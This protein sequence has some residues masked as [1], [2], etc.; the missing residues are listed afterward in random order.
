MVPHRPQ[1]LG[2]P[3]PALLSL[4]QRRPQ[5]RQ[6]AGAVRG[7]AQGLVVAGEEEEERGRGRG[8]RGWRRRAGLLQGCVKEK[9]GGG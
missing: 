3:G 8:G 1:P 7:E 5:L 9:G 6:V 4:G 2:A